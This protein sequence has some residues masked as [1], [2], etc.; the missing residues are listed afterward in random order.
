[1]KKTL[2]ELRKKKIINFKQINLKKKIKKI[3]KHFLESNKSIDDIWMYG[4]FTDNISDL[5]LI[6]VYKKIPVKFT[7]PNIIKNLSLMDPL[8]LLIKKGK[9]K[10]FYLKILKFFQ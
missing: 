4:N 3:L 9:I 5:D 1:M 10:F 2:L 7:F 6:V 8:Y